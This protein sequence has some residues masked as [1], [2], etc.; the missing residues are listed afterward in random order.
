MRFHKIT[1]AIISSQLLYACGGGGDT[2]SNITP[3]PPSTAPTSPTVSTVIKT[4]V[5]TG[6]GSVYV[7]GQR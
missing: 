2:S 7:D 1:L 5:V 4:G 3:I 6:F